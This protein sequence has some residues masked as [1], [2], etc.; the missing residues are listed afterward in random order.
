MGMNR[1]LLMR[2]A[3]VDIGEIGMDIIG[4]LWSFIRLRK[5]Y[6]ILPIMAIAVLFGGLMIFGQSSVLAPFIYTLF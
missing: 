1:A 2:R 4:E 6:W 3:P 5:K